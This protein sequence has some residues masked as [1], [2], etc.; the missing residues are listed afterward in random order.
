MT[1]GA[2]QVLALSKPGETEDV[3]NAWRNDVGPTDLSRA[4]Q[5]HPD[6]LR[7]QYA[8]DQLMNA[9]HSSDSHESAARYLFRF[10]EIS[11]NSNQ[12]INQ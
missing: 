9:L 10:L 6:T 2:S 11:S 1:S 7:A 12:L 5:E 8:T 3:I 4:K